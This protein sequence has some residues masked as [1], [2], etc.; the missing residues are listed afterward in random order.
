MPSRRNETGGWAKPLIPAADFT[1]DNGFRVIYAID[2][3]NPIICLQLYVRVGSVHEDISTSGFAHFIE[4]LTFKSTVNYPDNTISAAIPR[5]GG[6]INAYTDYDSTCYYMM[7]PSEEL[8]EGLQILSDIAFRALFST[9]DVHIEKDIILEEIKQYANEPDSSF[10]DWI[11]ATYFTSSPLKKPVLGSPSSVS[12]AKADSLNAFYN[13]HY[14]PMNSFLVVTGNIDARSIKR[15]VSSRF[16]NWLKGHRTS[17]CNNPGSPE[18]NG[19]RYHSS[20]SKAN[21]D[22]LA[23][24]LPELRDRDPLYNAQLIITK[25]FASGKQSTL[26]KRLVEKDRSAVEIQLFSICG[27][28]PGISIIQ[29]LPS[30]PDRVIDI[31]YAFYD[32]WLTVRQKFFLP[33]DI[34]LLKNEILN[35][36]LYEFEYIESLASSLGNDQ[37][38]GDYQRFYDFP[39]Q[40]C[41]VDEMMLAKCLSQYW[42]TGFL[43][44]YYRGTRSPSPKL[45]KNIFKLFTSDSN[46]S[47]KRIELKTSAFF[48]WH[49]CTKINIVPSA[50]KQEFR[51]TRLDGGMRLLLKYVPNKP[52][53]GMAVVT[54]VSQL[55]ELP[56]QR[57]MNYLASNLLLFGTQTKSY[58]Q[59]QKTCL[60]HGFNLKI[61]HLPETTTLRGKCLVRSIEPMLAL[62]SEMLLEPSFPQKYLSMVKAAIYDSIRREKS[63]PLSWAFAGWTDQFLGKHNNLSRPFSGIKATHKIKLDEI[64]DW[65]AR[66]YQI[67]RFTL[68]LAGNFDFDSMEELCNRYFPGTDTHVKP[69]NHLPFYNSGQPA[70]KSLRTDS[71]QSNLILGGWGCPG[72]DIKSVTAFYVLSQII[73]G[74]LGSRFF[75]ILREKYGFTYQAGFDLISLRELGWWYAYAVCDKQDHMQVMSLMLEILADTASCG[76]SKDELA[77]AQNYLKGMHRL[78]M[79]SLGWQASTLGVLYALGYD[80]DYFINRESRINS[81]DRDTLV[82]IAARCFQPD[83][84]V[85]RTER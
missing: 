83:G 22:Y 39:T 54:P 64:R 53:I 55:C 35:S 24:V 18:F 71:N 63:S 30:D 44:I 65:Y 7:I 82:E 50:I 46:L 12:A 61:S 26:F 14:R 81:V 56:E 66:Y 28:W 2:R 40:L 79:E 51:D 16:H 49:E 77:A 41:N 70:R 68:C 3:S 1:L 62:T 47:T 43:S 33:D 34:G 45:G 58:D 59:V 17:R 29:V 9:A 31:I 20:Y 80:Y 11:Q 52:T 75:Y 69:I 27:Q 60:R 19:F 15:K 5:L 78:D 6:M 67:K 38:A 32:E 42:H 8:D 57:G 84:L 4:H 21:G 48:P 25:A 76:V 10:L 37:L 13:K 23:F 73:G 74:D 72:A 85:I 36:W